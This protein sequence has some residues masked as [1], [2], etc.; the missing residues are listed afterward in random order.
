[1][2]DFPAPLR[3][4]LGLAVTTVETVRESMKTLPRRTAGFPVTVLSAAAQLSLRAQQQYA[5][6]I[7][8]GD[9]VV[10]ALRGIPD[11]PPAWAQFDDEPGPVG[12]SAVPGSRSSA[13]DRVTG[14][15]DPS[16]TGRSGLF[17]DDLDDDLGE[18]LADEFDDD[19]DD[20][21][22]VEIALD[23]DLSPALTPAD[24]TDGATEVIV[25]DAPRTTQ[26]RE[27]HTPPAAKSPRS[28]PRKSPAKRAAKA[29]LP[30]APP[31]PL[32]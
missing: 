19:L 7:S 13:F 30:P 32:V 2:S 4:T 26:P 18:E 28:A 14:R 9:E 15:P 6:L 12:L 27:P 3:A 31:A 8:K 20:G 21:V 16:P 10:G 23:D 24:D 5:A 11:E 22:A 25:A 17:D 1:M 29:G